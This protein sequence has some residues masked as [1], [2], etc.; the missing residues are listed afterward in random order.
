VE[1]KND[2]QFQLQHH[3]RTV[4]T[5]RNTISE[6]EKERDS[7]FQK[8]YEMEMMMNEYEERNFELE[9]REMDVRYSL[10]ILESAFPVLLFW[11]L[12]VVFKW[13]FQAAISTKVSNAIA[14]PVSVS[15]SVPTCNNCNKF[16]ARI[17]D[18][19][20]RILRLEKDLRDRDNAITNEL[21]SY[22]QDYIGAN[23]NTKLRQYWPELPRCVSPRNQLDRDRRLSL[24][25]EVYVQTLQ[26]A[27]DIILGI[28]NDF[29][30]KLD[31]MQ[32]ILTD[33]H[34]KLEECERKLAIVSSSRAME[35]HLLEKT[36]NLESDIS[37]L[38]QML[39]TRDEEKQILIQKEK[40][41]TEEL[42]QFNAYL[43]ECKNDEQ[44][45]RRRL[46][47][48]RALSREQRK[49][50]ELKEQEMKEYERT[51]NDRVSRNNIGLPIFRFIPCLIEPKV[52]NFSYL[53]AR[54]Q[55]KQLEKKIKYLT[56]ETENQEV[57]NGE[58]KE[59]VET[60]EVS[61]MGKKVL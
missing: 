3:I 45:I 1:K 9:E 59:E 56:R 26:Q 15:S 30:R 19:E 23:E 8:T 60:L 44:E 24:Q 32:Q 12:Y 55:V 25:E 17:V 36:Q 48:E 34:W 58:L 7:A 41:L 37:T 27:D 20:D 16:K 33:K 35:N 13:Y 52:T 40:R 5:L 22:L 43:V 54:S 11:N 10:Q 39:R 51:T 57:T 61:V 50:L 4:N 31:E 49:E 6:L 47:N 46:E 53:Y 29:K 14:L 38:K 2:L 18:L 42:D 28:E 21:C